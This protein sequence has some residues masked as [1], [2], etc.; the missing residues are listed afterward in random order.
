MVEEIALWAICLK[1]IFS[2]ARLLF[3]RFQKADRM[4]ECERKTKN[5]KESYY[6]E[7]FFFY[8]KLLPVKNGIEN[9]S[10]TSYAYSSSS[11]L[12]SNPI[13]QFHLFWTLMI[14]IHVQTY[15]M[16]SIELTLCVC[17]YG[18]FMLNAIVTKKNSITRKKGK[19]QREKKKKLREYFRKIISNKNICL[20][21]TLRIYYAHWY[22][23]MHLQW[24]CRIYLSICIDYSLLRSFFCFHSS[25]LS[26]I[27]IRTSHECMYACSYASF[28]FINA[29]TRKNICNLFHS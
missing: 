21:Y 24:L 13:E 17:V 19:Q 20:C 5:A 10:P 28:L 22:L 7:K 14:N 26:R 1:E 11:F 23:P 18:S 15:R 29:R 2:Y 4:I 6:F 3:I 12:F 27:S 8:S 25:P 16:A 9:S